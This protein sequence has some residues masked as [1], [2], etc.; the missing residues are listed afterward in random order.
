MIAFVRGGAGAVRLTPFLTLLASAACAVAPDSERGAARVALDEVFDTGVV[1]TLSE[2]PQ[3]SIATLGFFAERV[4]G[5]FLVSD[6]QLPRIRSYH[7]DGRL[8][9]AFGRFG[10]GPFEFQGINGLAETT[11]GRVA[12]IDS[13]HNRL[14]Y[15]TGDL[16]PDTMVQLPGVPSGLEPMGHDL[17]MGL[18]LATEGTQGVSRFFQRP[19]L[20][21]RL[22]DNK[23]AWSAYIYPFV[24]IERPYWASLVR[25]SFEVA[26]DSIYMASSLRYPV[27]ILNTAG[28][29]IGE[30]G[31][32]PPTFQPVP[33]LDRGAL[34]PNNAARIPDLLGGRST[35]SHIA[36]VGSHLVVVH[37]R[38]GSQGSE[39][40]FGSYHSSFDIYDRHTGHKLYEDLAV[41]ENSRILG[42]GRH[43]Y[44]L[45]DTRFPPWR[46][47]KLSFREQDPG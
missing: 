20:L 47:A 16:V 25:F 15:L 42:G 1:T 17:L 33:V 24:P 26:G 37:G 43:L 27:A 4:N 35:I 2:D 46:I 7:E 18:R 32:P 19:R 45:Q 10:E 29:S 28:D 3:D 14:T 34:A 36:V 6:G 13:R 30:I 12:V 21:H 5:G 22:T 8:E 31:V 44:L 38:F 39:G 11:S 23:V 41:P 40:P 9:A